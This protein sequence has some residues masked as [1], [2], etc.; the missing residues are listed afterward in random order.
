M[1]STDRRSIIEEQQKRWMNDRQTA[2]IRDQVYVET[3]KQTTADCGDTSSSSN[4]RDQENQKNLED[5]MD[6]NNQRET[7]FF[8][9]RFTDKLSL[10]IREEI[11]NEMKVS[12]VS[13]ADLAER[14]ESYLEAELGTHTCKICFELM[15]SPVH[16]PVLL[17]PCGH[18]FCKA[19]IESHEKSQSKNELNKTNVKTLNF[20]CPYCRTYVVSTATNQSL[21]DLIDTFAKQRQK[22]VS[23][24][25]TLNSIF[26]E[27]LISTNKSSKNDM[28]NDDCKSSSENLDQKSMYDDQIK[29]CIMRRGILITELEDAEGNLSAVEKKR[30][31]LMKASTHL[32]KERVLVVNKILHL[33]EEKDLIDVHLN[34]Q[35]SKYSNLE[36][37]EVHS[38]HR[39]DLTQNTLKSL[40]DELEKI[41]YLME[42]LKQKSI[43]K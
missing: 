30:N 1:S 21:K 38:K 5:R 35:K 16:T 25:C 13:S 2:L 12:Q 22:I 43:K 20:Q 24:K 8:L 6:P 19:C 4:T 40:Q 7:D 36:K 14:M 26:P 39:I 29:S 37:E 3:K 42:G 31:V 15:L 41:S 33:Q 28:N 23:D 18:T 10:R 11:K 17:F 27:K 34:E 9:Q 32:K